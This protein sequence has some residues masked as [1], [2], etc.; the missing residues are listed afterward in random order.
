MN[1]I[2]L[3]PVHQ[4]VIPL[5]RA[6]CSPAVARQHITVI[7]RAWHAPV[8]PDV[9]RLVASEFVTNVLLHTSPPAGMRDVIR[10]TFSS[11]LRHVGLTVHDLDDAPLRP[12]GPFRD[13]DL[14]EGGRGLE[15]VRKLADRSGLRFTWIGG[16][17]EH[18]KTAWAAWDI[19]TYVT[20][21]GS[22]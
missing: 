13:W 20:P 10:L 11:G 4:C 5:R 15:M 8:D 14:A 3:A 12:P 21:G 18:G 16:Q 7:A 17:G 19:P 6:L 22:S 2:V 1:A 9:L